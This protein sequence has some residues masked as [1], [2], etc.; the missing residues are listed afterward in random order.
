MYIYVYCVC[1]YTYVYIYIYIYIYIQ[2]ERGSNI[3]HPAVP[4]P[5]RSKRK[6]LL[7]CVSCATVP[8]GSRCRS[9]TTWMWAPCTP[10]SSSPTDCS[11]PPW[12]RPRRAPTAS[13]TGQSQ[14][15][16]VRL[17]GCGEERSSQQGMTNIHI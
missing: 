16:S 9:F 13:T 4:F 8:T 10:T 5:R 7:R 12:C 15:A 1:V 17:S 11:R 2:R 6:L 14:T 3:H